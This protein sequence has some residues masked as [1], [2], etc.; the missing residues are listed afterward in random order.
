MRVTGQMFGPTQTG[1]VGWGVVGR[2]WGVDAPAPSPLCRP[3]SFGQ[4]DEYTA[5]LASDTTTGTKTKGKSQSCQWR[6]VGLVVWWCDT[7]TLRM[8]IGMCTCVC[9]CD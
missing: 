5:P 9:V 8:D 3:S 2:R 6:R 7:E 4:V 1:S